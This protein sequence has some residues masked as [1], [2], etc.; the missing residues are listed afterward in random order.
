MIRQHIDTFK[1]DATDMIFSIICQANTSKKKFIEYQINPFW[2][3]VTNDT[4]QWLEKD[5][6]KKIFFGT[7]NVSIKTFFLQASFFSLLRLNWLY[8]YLKYVIIICYI[9]NVSD[10]GHR[11]KSSSFFFCLFEKT[12]LNIGNLHRLILKVSGPVS[13]KNVLSCN[14]FIGR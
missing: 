9:Y 5:L 1:R 3:P 6:E 4:K 13:G 11:I 7:G 10:F 8:V 14:L 12:I 2:Y